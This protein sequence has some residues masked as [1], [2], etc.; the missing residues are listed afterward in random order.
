MRYAN[1]S[2]VSLA[3]LVVSVAASADDYPQWL[4]PKRDNVYRETGLAPTFPPTG[5]KVLWRAPVGGGYAGIAVAGNRVIVTDR[6]LAPGTSNPSDPFKRGTIPGT[7]RV[8][9]LDDA[10]GKELWKVEYDC[11]YTISY[12]S[13]PRANPAVD[14]DRVYTLG[15]QGDLYCI[16]LNSGKTLWNKQLGKTPAIWGY[17]GSPVVEDDLVVVLSTGQPLLTAFHKATGE[18]AWTAG[19]A[20]DPGYVPPTPHTFPGGR[21]Q[22]VQYYPAGVIGVDAKT[23]KVLWEQP[24]GPEQ[25]GVTIVTPLFVGDDTFVLSSQY[26]GAAAIRITADNKPEVLWT[27]KSKGRVPTALHSLH[28]QMVLH[29]GHIYGV[30]NGGDVLCM[31]PKT[32]RVLWTDTKPLLGDDERRMWT[33]GFLTPWQ[34]DPARSAKHFYL[35][36]ET[37]DLIL[38]NLSPKGYTEIGRAH[39]LEAVNMDAKR[40]TLW[41]HPAYAHRSIYWRNDKEIVRASLAE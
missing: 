16:D 11:P 10:T 22:I 37:G 31:D 34:P 39:L 27:A 7:E 20:K 26:T 41:S 14:G 8:L 13:G 36:T 3:L 15:A 33:A 28:S 1:R 38:C 24:Y 29:E 21:R 12:A 6:R 5:P 40:P 23:G 30:N 19:Q 32:G 35:G 4:G 18:V 25:N 2:L 9:C 17:S